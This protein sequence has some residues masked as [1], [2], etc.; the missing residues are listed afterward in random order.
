MNPNNWYA[1]YNYFEGK[2]EKWLSSDLI[3]A[4]QSDNANLIIG[5]GGSGLRVISAVQDELFANIAPELSENEESLE[6]AYPRTRFLY[7]DYEAE[8]QA[9]RNT[10]LMTVFSLGQYPYYRVPVTERETLRGAAGKELEARSHVLSDIIRR[11]ATDNETRRI[12]V[13]IIAGLA[14]NMG[15]GAFLSLAFQVREALAHYFIEP[16]VYG[17]FFLQPHIGDVQY[18]AENEQWAFNLIS[19][20]LELDYFTKMPWEWDKSYSLSG[21]LF[22]NY[23]LVPWGDSASG[24]IAGYISQYLKKETAGSLYAG[25]SGSFRSA[26]AILSN[27]SAGK[28]MVFLQ[29]RKSVHQQ[30]LVRRRCAGSLLYLMDRQKAAEPVDIGK[31]ALAEGFSLETLVSRL[32]RQLNIDFGSIRAG[33]AANTAKPQQIQEEYDRY[34]HSLIRV[35]TE[36]GSSLVNVIIDDYIFALPKNYGSVYSYINLI[37]AAIRLFGKWIERLPYFKKSQLEQALLDLTNAQ[38]SLIHASLFTRKRNYQRYLEALENYKK[39][40]IYEKETEIIIEAWERIVIY[41]RELQ[42]TRLNWVEQVMKRCEQ[43]LAA[44]SPLTAPYTKLRDLNIFTEEEAARVNQLI[45][46]CEQELLIGNQYG[47]VNHTITGEGMACYLVDQAA[48]YAIEHYAISESDP[49]KD[50]LQNVPLPTLFWRKDDQDLESAPVLFLHLPEE[51]HFKAEWV[52]KLEA[53]YVV[54]PVITHRPDTAECYGFRIIPQ[55]F[56]RE[57]DLDFF[58]TLRIENQDAAVWMRD[59]VISRLFSAQSVSGPEKAYVS[60]IRSLQIPKDVS[61]PVRPILADFESITHLYLP[62]KIVLKEN[63]LLDGLDQIEFVRLFGKEKADLSQMYFPKSLR[64]IDFRG[65]F[66]HELPESL[67]GLRKLEKL[68]LE[69]VHL[70]TMKSS[71]LNL[72]ERIG[73]TVDERDRGICIKNLVIDDM[74]ASI[75]LGPVETL[76]I[77]FE[78]RESAPQSGIVEEQTVNGIGEIK[79]IFLGDGEVGKTRTIRR[80]LR[81]GEQFKYTEDRTPGILISDKIERINDRDIKIHFWDFG[82][83]D[84]FYSTHRMFMT[85]QTVYVILLNARESNLDERA[86]Y[87][88][89]NVLHFAGKDVPVLLVINKTDLNEDAYL[90]SSLRDEYKKNIRG[91]SYLSNETFGRDEFKKAIIEP[92]YRI[93][94]EMKSVTTDFPESWRLLADSMQKNNASFLREN[95]VRKM[96][97]DSMGKI[98]SKEL[99]DLL[100]W[101]NRIGVS[102]CYRGDMGLADFIVLN[103]HWVTNAIY[104][105]LAN[106]R[107]YTR[108]G[109]I[110]SDD[111][112]ELLLEEKESNSEDRTEEPNE[113]ICVDPTIHYRDLGEVSFVLGVLRYFHLSFNIDKGNEFIPALCTG[114]ISARCEEIQKES[115]ALHFKYEY[116]YLPRLILH[117][118]MVELHVYLDIKSVAREAAVF[119]LKDR[120]LAAAV[121]IRGNILHIYIVCKET[122]DAPGVFLEILRETLADI[123][124]TFEFSPKEFIVYTEDGKSADFDFN[125]LISMREH[126]STNRVYSSVF[127]R[128]IYLA[129]LLNPVSQEEVVWGTF[130]KDLVSACLNLQSHEQ[131]KFGDEVKCNV[132]LCDQ[133]RMTGR[134]AVT[135]YLGGRAGSGKTD[136]Y[137][138]RD[139]TVLDADNR[140]LYILEGLILSYRPIK[141]SPGKYLN[142][143]Y[144]KKHLKKLLNNY[145]PNGLQYLCIINCLD[146]DAEEFEKA[147]DAY[148]KCIRQENPGSYIAQNTIEETDETYNFIRTAETRYSVGGAFAKVYHIFVLTEK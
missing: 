123:N 115:R 109:L 63:K 80:I 47:A 108:H 55:L 71:I 112:S 130:K 24:T 145:N 146:T 100:E 83:Q 77:W 137:G 51:E 9:R 61:E 18:G 75:L 126:S 94:G 84:I 68:D 139:I 45:S 70:D 106:G 53:Q 27:T 67:T 86:R 49:S 16:A 10:P 28:F 131:A 4:E 144:L 32:D 65:L 119:E 105:I 17:Y 56:N 48:S 93:I 76:R 87:W 136:N 43:Q 78:K 148:L 13:H 22:N 90:S 60:R 72:A 79:V 39:A 2:E 15:S 40:Q 122:G 8:A 95:D 96:L 147:W 117:R 11:F 111:L 89:Y 1:R 62:V 82:G 42:S 30:E 118:L 99:G 85:Q 52:K 88:L 141:E 125:E 103:P 107:K 50:I 102:F 140:E 35:F 66:M 21:M 29:G 36:K 44:I 132:Y 104:I 97:P 31:S 74:N 58:H 133:L 128:D 20:L 12:Q 110:K 41:M 101:F 26:E 91:V 98:N 120:G 134:N 54:I 59:R 7:V 14:G 64:T 38:E 5:L 33:F 25:D 143:D 37:E 92:L 34:T 46:E 114:D 142:K 6:A 116:E 121:L 19:A 113:I 81:D 23:F 57:M 129:Q 127:K 124:D 138:E 73:F 69:D 135:E 3:K